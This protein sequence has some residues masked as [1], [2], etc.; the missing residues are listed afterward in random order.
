MTTRLFTVETT[1]SDTN[2]IGQITLKV[3][4]RVL[5]ASLYD[6]WMTAATMLHGLEPAAIPD[7]NFAAWYLWSLQCDRDPITMAKAQSVWD[8]LSASPIDLDLDP[9]QPVL[10]KTT[11]NA[12]ALILDKYT[13]LRCGQLYVTDVA[14]LQRELVDLVDAAATGAQVTDKPAKADPFIDDT[15]DLDDGKTFTH[16]TRIP[17]E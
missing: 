4:D 5:D 15:I 1:P 12:V 10:A 14:E 6:D 3:D 9:R 7:G 13:D 2:E 11:R 16:S 8:A 17:K